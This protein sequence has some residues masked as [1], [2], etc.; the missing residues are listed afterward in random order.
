MKANF[1]T[2]A[3]VWAEHSRKNS[4]KVQGQ[5]EFIP[6]R[7]TSKKAPVIVMTGTQQ[8]RIGYDAFVGMGAGGKLDVA[9]LLRDWGGGDR[10]ALDQLIPEVHSELHRLA[11]AYLARERPGHTLQPT[12]L[13]NEAYLKLAGERRMQCR[14]R[15]HFIA[16]AA[17]LMR[18]ILVDYC[19]GKQFQKRG[20]GAVRVTF[21]ENLEVGGDRSADLLALDQAL[22]RLEAQDARKSRIAELRYFGGLSVQEVAE[23]LTISVA[24]VMR[25]WRL[26]KAWLQ[27]ELS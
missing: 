22:E 14:D 10:S 12:A 20:G 27:R 9:R 23:A 5:K 15:A 16:V 13:V 6:V 4:S 3:I 11:R 19:R 25:E 7:L 24:T 18:F 26:T 17:R 8:S 2:G 21:D 1:K